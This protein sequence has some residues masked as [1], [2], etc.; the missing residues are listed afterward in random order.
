MKQ[1]GAV[2]TS[3]APE[4]AEELLSV[5]RQLGYDEADTETRPSHD[6]TSTRRNAGD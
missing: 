1:P 5:Y 3:L 4:D 6:E 2:H